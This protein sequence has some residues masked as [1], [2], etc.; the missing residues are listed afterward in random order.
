MRKPAS[1]GEAKHARPAFSLRVPAAKK[2]QESKAA[3][4]LPS[5]A[6]L[7]KNK[8]SKRSPLPQA[9]RKEF[10]VQDHVIKML[11]SDDDLRRE[12]EAEMAAIEGR[13]DEDDDDGDDD[14]DDDDDDGDDD[15]G[16]DD[17][18]DDDDDD[19]DDDDE[20]EE[21]LSPLEQKLKD[22]RDYITGKIQE[23]LDKVVASIE[24]QTTEVELLEKDLDALRELKNR[25]EDIEV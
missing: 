21:E 19:D 6:E 17:D 11:K 3:R 14:D 1:A 5:V 2:T 16:D 18:G 7:L 15:D 20:E 23:V 10:V 9:D 22:N 25:N 4:T 24:K 12:A 8:R 13:T